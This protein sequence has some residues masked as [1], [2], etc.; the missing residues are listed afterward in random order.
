MDRPDA[1]SRLMLA[2]ADDERFRRDADADAD[3]RASSYV[4]WAGRL[5]LSL[6]LAFARGVASDV[7]RSS[8]IVS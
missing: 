5:D 4:D 2:E 3:G 8:L 7:A 6:M 1:D